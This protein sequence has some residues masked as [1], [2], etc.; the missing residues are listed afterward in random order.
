MKEQNIKQPVK[1][2]AA[3]VPVI[4]QLEALECGA[5]CLTM[6]LAYYEKHIPLEQVR[7]DCG[8]S[9]DLIGK[10]RDIT[11][12]TGKTTIIISHNI[13][14]I[15]MYDNVIVLAKG[16]DGAG[17]IAYAGSPAG[18]RNFFGVNSYVDILTKINANDEGGLG[19]ASDYIR[20]FARLRY[21]GRV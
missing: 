20:D 3:K 15:E 7:S 16:S 8:V 13:V 18:I 6:I 10:L 5:A 2:K 19:Q 1:G 11:H 12:Q 14:N 9:R 4:I 17:G 21:Q